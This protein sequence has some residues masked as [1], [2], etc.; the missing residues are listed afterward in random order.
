MELGIDTDIVEVMP[1]IHFQVPE[2]TRLTAAQYRQ[3]KQRLHIELL[4]LQRWVIDG[5][6]R[7][8][9]LVDGRDTAG[10]GGTIKHFVQHLIERKT[11]DRRGYRV[12]SLGVPTRYESSRW[13]QRYQRHL[14]RCGEIV[15]FDRSWYNRALVEPAMEYC[16]ERQYRVFMATVNDWE[17][18]LLC[19]GIHL[20]KIYL[21]I[22]RATQ[23]RRI[24]GRKNSP[25]KNWKLSKHDLAVL[26]KWDSITHYE[27]QML[28]T[29]SSEQAPWAVIDA[30]NKRVARLNAMRY[31]LAAVDYNGRSSRA[32]QGGDLLDAALPTTQHRVVSSHVNALL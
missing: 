23:W 4:K 26:G 14:P 21:S 15:F 3:E 32:T 12:V 11:D 22:D 5:G 13:L 30:N 6:Q 24:N 1:T 27:T 29:T 25:L 31:V 20:I 17:S 28:T 19:H 8:A 18:D 7:I 10:K 9:V 2:Y 16:S